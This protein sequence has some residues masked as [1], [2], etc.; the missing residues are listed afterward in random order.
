[1]TTIDALIYR[2][3]VLGQEEIAK[4][5]YGLNTGLR[6]LLLLLDGKR[7][8]GETAN[9]LG[10][11]DSLADDL[12]TL[13]TFALIESIPVAGPTPQELATARD[14]DAPDTF[15]LIDG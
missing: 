7:T 2:K 6:R 5:R 1:M 15:V 10:R 4:R 11:P 9:L 3:T 14:S 8:I 12:D 13:Q